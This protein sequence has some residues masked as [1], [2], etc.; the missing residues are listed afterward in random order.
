MPERATPL[1]D[2]AQLHPARL[3]DAHSRPAGFDAVYD[4]D[5]EGLRGCRRPLARYAAGTGLAD[6]GRRAAGPSGAR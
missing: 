4:V 1:P 2:D 3:A 5:I 6:D